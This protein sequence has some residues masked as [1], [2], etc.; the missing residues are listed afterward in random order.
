VPGLAEIAGI[1]AMPGFTAPKLLWLK[2]HEPAAFA[3]MRHILLAKDYVRL[4]LIGVSKSETSDFDAGEIATDM[5]DAA[6]TLLLDEAARDW[7]EPMLSAC[8][9]SRENLP[10]LLEGSAPSE[11]LRP[12]LRAEWGIERATVVAAG[13]GDAAAGAVGLG[14]VGEG[15][16]FISLGT[17]AQFFVTRERYAPKPEK[18]VH[19]FAHAL[20]GRWFE[21]AAL[22]NGASPLGWL[23]RIL[24]ETD[25]DTL[26][27]KLDARFRGPSPLLFL[28][29]L[30]GERTPLNDPEA[31]GV[32]AGLDAAS[33]SI[34]LVQAVL[35]GV[36]FSLVD[37]RDAVGW[38]GDGPLPV[39]G[40]GARNR[41]WLRLIASALGVPVGRIAGADK[42]PAFGAARLARLALTGEPAA[43]VC[44]KPPLTETIRPEPA[45]HDAYAERVAAFRQ[46][47]R[48]LRS[49]RTPTPLP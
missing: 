9:I 7:S 3:R 8:G 33:D 15:D 25:I 16:S 41:F 31:R 6:G 19:A 1:V 43:D 39:I 49:R 48:S 18:L 47:Y 2:R 4:R 13:A 11:V 37:A 44:V 35:E 23:A 12:A 30:S 10:R 27:G 5:S 32:F 29:Y 14:A 21:M 20:P 45:L 24:G 36:A 34:D 17:S 22:L 28:P 42:G 46:L 26:V 40:G 38:H